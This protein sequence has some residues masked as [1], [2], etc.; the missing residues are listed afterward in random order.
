MKPGRTSKK[1][2]TPKNKINGSGPNLG[3]PDD[4]IDELVSQLRRHDQRVSNIKLKFHEYDCKTNS[5]MNVVQVMDDVQ[6]RL[7]LMEARIRDFPTATKEQILRANA[8]KDLV[9]FAKSQGLLYVKCGDIEVRLCPPAVA[10]LPIT[11]QIKI[12]S[13]GTPADY[14]FLFWS[15]PENTFEDLD[16]KPKGDE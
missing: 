9:A 8:L 15:A 6:D 5:L 12:V 14:E 3:T 1:D 11:E 7:H 13:E 10:T 16:E 2:S 4:R